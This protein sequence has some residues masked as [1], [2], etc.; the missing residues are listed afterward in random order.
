M[1]LIVQLPYTFVSKLKMMKLSALT[2]PAS[3]FDKYISQV[4]ELDLFD[5][6][7]SSI[8]AIDALDLATL[9]KLGDRAYAPGKWTLKYVLQHVIDTERIFAYRALRFA[10]NDKSLLPGFDENLFANNSEAENRN[11][12]ELIDELRQVRKGTAIMFRSFSE[13]ALRRTGTV[14]G[15][16]LPVLALGFIVVGHQTHHFKIMEERY[17]PLQQI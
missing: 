4:E 17:Y 1:I 15:T 8:K 13:A 9:E 5:A 14:Y 3:Y 6:L 12:A 7:E 11:M 2:V 10:R 16:E